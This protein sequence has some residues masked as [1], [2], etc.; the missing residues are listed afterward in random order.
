MVIKAISSKMITISILFIVAI[1]AIFTSCNNEDI[2]LPQY[3]IE[4]INLQNNWEITYCESEDCIN[5]IRRIYNI[6]VIFTPEL[7]YYHNSFR[8]YIKLTKKLD[9]HINKNSDLFLLSLGKIGDADKTYFNGKLIGKSG[10]FPPNEFSEWNTKRYYLINS[11]QIK[12]EDLNTLE[13][14]IACYGFNRMI[15]DVY[16]KPITTKEYKKLVFIENLKKYFPLFCNIGAGITFFIIFF[17]LCYNKENRSKYIF[18]LLQLIPGLIVIAEPILTF[19]LYKNTFLR[20]KIFGIAW[21]F[22]VFFHL[23]FLHRLYLYKRCKIELLLFCLTIVLLFKILHATD[24]TTIKTTGIGTIIILTSLA[25]YNVSLHVEQLLKKNVIA[26]LFVPIGITLAITAVHDGFVFLSIFH[27]KIYQFFGY[28]FN[29]PIFQYTSNAIFI[30]AGLIIVHQYILMSKTIEN[31]N[32]I[33]EQ[34]VDE[35]TK[36]LQTSLENLSKAIELGFFTYPRKNSHKYSPQ[37]EPKIKKAIIFINNNYRENISR[38][39][40][41]SMLDLH[42]DYFSKA[43]RF[44]TGKKINDYINELRIKEALKLVHDTNMNILD[45]A[46]QVGFEN[47]KTFNR[48]FKKF[49]GKN[50]TNYRKK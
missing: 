22:L 33:L 20:I 24:I 39:G 32:I 18:F 26:F 10:E 38:E 6:P 34:K 17:M 43:F 28:Q 49:T 9:I 29:S 7:I 4:K 5:P 25:L 15:G 14:I 41:A 1:C 40:L 2:Y 42:P 11:N 16:L 8:G 46:M 13:I 27:F 47:L 50:P 12:H 35:R 36:Q 44:F 31:I 48:A 3:T 21:S 23:L 19:P 45:I 37:L 30:G